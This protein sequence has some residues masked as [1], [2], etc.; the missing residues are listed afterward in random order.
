[1]CHKMEKMWWKGQERIMFVYSKEK[2]CPVNFLKWERKKYECVF[3]NRNEK[4][5]QWK[6]RKKYVYMQKTT[7]TKL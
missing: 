3:V 7:V 5:H 2:V 6:E 1:M 4:K